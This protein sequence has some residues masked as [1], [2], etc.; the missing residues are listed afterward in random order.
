MI[1]RRFYDGWTQREVGDELGISQMQVSRHLS[2]IL[3]TLRKQMGDLAAP[4]T[5]A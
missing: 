4:S 3:A 5:A 1:R 2:R